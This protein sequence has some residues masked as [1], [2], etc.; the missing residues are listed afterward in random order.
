MQK[1]LA[2]SSAKGSNCAITFVL[3]FLKRII[4]DIGLIC[5]VLSI[6]KKRK[7]AAKRILAIRQYIFGS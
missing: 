5:Q 3:F 4:V 7:E 1:P 6:I 2:V